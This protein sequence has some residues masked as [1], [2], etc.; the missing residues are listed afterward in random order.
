M[1]CLASNSKIIFSYNHPM[2]IPLSI[3]LGFT[4]GI[5]NVIAF[6]ILTDFS[7]VAI[8]RPGHR[9]FSDA[10]PMLFY[11]FNICI[12]LIPAFMSFVAFANHRLKPLDAVTRVFLG[13][14]NGIW[15]IISTMTIIGVVQKSSFE[16]AFVLLYWILFNIATLLFVALPGVLRALW[17]AR[18]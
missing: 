11:V 15:L 17:L 5:L 9:S 1:G 8:D 7:P 6:L 3:L 10:Y 4:V 2:R 12:V 16:G 18:R 14:F 13:A